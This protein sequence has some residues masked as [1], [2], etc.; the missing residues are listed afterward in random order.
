M[1]DYQSIAQSIVEKKAPGYRKR[2]LVSSGDKYRVVQISEVAYFFASQRYVVLVTQDG[3]RHLLD[4]SLDTIAQQLD[5]EAFFR[6]NRTYLIRF[7][8]I[9]NMVKWTKGRVKIDLSPAADEDV[10][11][12]VGKAQAFRAWLG[13]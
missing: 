1:I 10:I 3:K 8:S 12:S 7:E 9:G 6:I 13:K 5:P 11:V 4:D 2:F